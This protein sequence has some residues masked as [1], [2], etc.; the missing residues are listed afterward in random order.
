MV[1]LADYFANSTEML[2]KKYTLQPKILES[3]LF[4]W[5]GGDEWRRSF[6]FKIPRSIRGTGIVTYMLVNFDGTCSTTH[7]IHGK[8][9]KICLH[10]WLIFMEHV[11]KYTVRPM[12]PMG[13]IPVGWF[14]CKEFTC[15][16]LLKFH[17]SWFL[18]ILISEGIHPRFNVEFI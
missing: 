5:T 8:N 7:G 18:S 6:P 1:G 4:P 11:G 2:Q 14:T 9:G 17:W 13:N 3:V 15:K 10:E 16:L 12:D